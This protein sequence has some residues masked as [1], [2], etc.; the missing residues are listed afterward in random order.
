MVT[1][2]KI[3]ILIGF[4]CVLVACVY[5]DTPARS[6]DVDN[7]KVQRI[8]K[9]ISEDDYDV[10]DRQKRTSESKKTHPGHAKNDHSKK[11]GRNHGT[12]S[13]TAT[14]LKKSDKAHPGKH[15]EHSKKKQENMGTKNVTATGLK[16]KTSDK[17][18]SIYANKKTDVNQKATVVGGEAKS[19]KAVQPVKVDPSEVADNDLKTGVGVTV[20][21]VIVTVLAI[22]A[23]ICISQ[24]EKIREKWANM[25]DYKKVTEE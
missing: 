7:Q 15:K 2:F 10:T 20:V 24:R 13:V 5:S 17:G 14:G 8:F 9:D 22:V 1:H 16:S 21:I 23:A 19:D 6:S 25:K 11:K 12:K 18:D 3:S 4:L